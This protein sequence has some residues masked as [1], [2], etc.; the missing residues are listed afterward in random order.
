MPAS[1][2]KRNKGRDRKA[3]KAAEKEEAERVKMFNKWQGW[4]HAKRTDGIAIIQCNHGFDVWYCQRY[5]I[6]F[7]VSLLHYLR[8]TPRI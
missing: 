5:L 3:K 1:S 6:Q 4:T 8:T 7:Q 2:R